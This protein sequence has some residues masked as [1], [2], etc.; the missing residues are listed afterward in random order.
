MSSPVVKNFMRQQGFAD[1]ETRK[2]FLF[3]QNDAPAFAGEESRRGRAGRAS[4]DDG[5]VVSERHPAKHGRQRDGGAIGTSWAKLFAAR[6]AGDAA[7]IRDDSEF[8]LF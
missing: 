3:A 5:D 7:S 8:Q 1:F 6:Q 2:N 4:S